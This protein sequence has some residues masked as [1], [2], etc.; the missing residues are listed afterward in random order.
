MRPT[1]GRIV[2]FMLSAAA[3]A[4]IMARRKSAETFKS[5]G[6]EGNPVREGDVFPMII[7]REGSDQPGAAVNGQVLLDGNDSYWAR[8]VA[9]CSDK[10][11]PGQWA[12]PVVPARVEPLPMQ[13][14][15]GGDQA[16]GAKIG[17]DATGTG[18]ASS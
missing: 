8:S 10:L 3:A 2:L 17:T 16:S 15:G 12:W 18:G 1:I 13:A 5:F 14:T 11:E 7:T 4:E 9:L 6:I